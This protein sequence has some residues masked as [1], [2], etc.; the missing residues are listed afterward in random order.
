MYNDNVVVKFIVIDSEYIEYD[1][2]F[3]INDA[4]EDITEENGFANIEVAEGEGRNG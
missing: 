4:I 1:Y 2:D 3:A